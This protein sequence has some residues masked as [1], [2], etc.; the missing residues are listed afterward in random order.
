MYAASVVKA[1]LGE[2]TTGVIPQELLTTNRIMERW[3]VANGNGLPTERWDDS[4]K[5]RPTPLDD[6]SAYEI[7]RIVMR[8]PTKTK[9]VLVAWLTWPHPTSVIAERFNVSPRTLEKMYGM[10]LHF[11]KYRIENT[12]HKT[13]LRLLRV[14]V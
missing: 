7:D 10:A 12:G 11:M 4:K 8:C 5:A 9:K 1:M 2:A 3:A 13:L 14:H 6:D